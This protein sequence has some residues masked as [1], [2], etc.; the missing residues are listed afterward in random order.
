MRRVEV[1]RFFPHPAERVFLRYTDHAGWTDWGGFGRVWVTREG[2]PDK[3][4]VGSVRAF[5]A[6]PGLREEVVLFEPPSRTQYRI[7]AGPVPIADHLGEVTFAPEGSGTKVTWSV[8]FRP[9]IPG[10]GWI[11]ERSLVM[12]FRRMLASLARDLDSRK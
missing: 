7:V 9:T 8:S 6:A 3:N 4:G 12:L 2:F 11:V 10:T 5:A 1:E